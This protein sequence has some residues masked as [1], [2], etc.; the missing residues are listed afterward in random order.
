MRL[1][2]MDKDRYD[3]VNFYPAG[4]FSGDRRKSI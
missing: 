2:I 3:L 4:V 1:G